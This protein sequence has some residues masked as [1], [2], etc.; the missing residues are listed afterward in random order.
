MQPVLRSGKV[1]LLFVSWFAAMPFAAAQTAYTWTGAVSGDWSNGANWNPA[2]V[3][4]HADDAH[5]GNSTRT[6]I[7]I[8]GARQIDRMDFAAGA[9]GYTFTLH[10]ASSLAIFAQSSPGATDDMSAAAFVSQ[11]SGWLDTT[12]IAGPVLMGSLSGSGSLTLGNQPVSIGALGSNDTYSGVIG[13]GGVAPML[14]KVGSG[15]LVL[16]GNNTF[17]GPTLIESGR[18][19]VDGHLD[20]AQTV[21][22]VGGGLSLHPATLAGAGYV[23]DVSMQSH[24][25]LWPGNVSPDT[26]LTMNT[27]GCNGTSNNVYTRIGNAGGVR[28][29][30]YLHL[31]FA[32]RAENCP[33]LTFWMLNAGEPMVVGESYLI[34]SMAS[35]TNFTPDNLD[36]AMAIPGYYQAHGYFVVTSTASASYIYFVVNDLGDRILRDGFEIQ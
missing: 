32:L 22:L 28:R 15:T 13:N 36:Y 19:Q 16:S 1:W 21:S 34:A 20:G 35:V 6:A 11:G 31:R 29:G 5:F 17:T 30:T 2:S 7:S 24:T 27:L 10:D 9:P 4:T 14:V 18:L 33:K 25:Y 12:Q 3:P 23:G 26:S 8:A